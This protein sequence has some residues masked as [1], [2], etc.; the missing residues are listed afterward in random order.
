MKWSGSAERAFLTGLL[1]AITTD[2][3]WIALEFVDFG[4][5]TGFSKFTNMQSMVVRV[6][7]KVINVRQSVAHW[8]ILRLH[9]LW[10]P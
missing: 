6:G 4:L 5:F 10:P 9:L 7:A 2:E 1:A 3:F 8:K